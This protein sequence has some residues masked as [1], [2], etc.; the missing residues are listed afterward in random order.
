MVYCVRWTAF[1]RLRRSKTAAG[2]VIRGHNMIHL[3]VFAA[4]HG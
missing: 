3:V 2:G 4:R 1:P